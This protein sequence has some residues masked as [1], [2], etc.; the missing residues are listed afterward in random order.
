MVIRTSNLDREVEK[1]VLEMQKTHS[2]LILLSD[3]GTMDIMELASGTTRQVKVRVNES[4]YALMT[5]IRRA[6]H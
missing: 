6:F 5:D 3:D 4:K 1:C 2:C